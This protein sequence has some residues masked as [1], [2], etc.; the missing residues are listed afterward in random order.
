M[1][2]SK[3]ADFLRNVLRTYEREQDKAFYLEN[4]GEFV[5]IVVSET[6]PCNCDLVRTIFT[7]YKDTE[8]L[9][10]LLQAFLYI[11]SKKGKRWACFAAGESEDISIR[12]KHPA[13]LSLFFSYRPDF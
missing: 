3:H 12:L 8:G 13:Y 5:G 6:D 10:D 7:H 1:D 9:K 2:K 11:C 4:S